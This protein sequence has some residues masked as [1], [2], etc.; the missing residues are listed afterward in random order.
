MIAYLASS[1]SAGVAIARFDMNLPV[2][3]ANHRYLIGDA[4]NV[5]GFIATERDDL[6]AM[7]LA[8]IVVLDWVDEEL[9]ALAFSRLT[10][11]IAQ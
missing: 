8:G 11:R 5:H 10:Q 9:I 2:R 7:N 3:T 1:P 4:D 6:R